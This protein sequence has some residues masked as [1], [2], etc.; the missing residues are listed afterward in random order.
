MT[1]H[2]AATWLRML[3]T[4]LAN[5]LAQLDPDDWDDVDN[6]ID[7]WDT[8]D[9]IRAMIAVHV[10]DLS[11]RAA[12]LLPTAEYDAATGTYHKTTPRTEKWDGFGV[13][14]ALGEPFIDADTGELVRAVP[15]DVLR[16]VLPACGPG[17]T[18]SKW[19]RRALAAH[20]DVERY[21]TVEWGTPVVVRGP[22]PK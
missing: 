22:K 21:S 5:D 8:L 15:V 3:E 9:R 7:A 13:V 11:T 6:T 14:G 16:E 19:K 1:P 10:R 12:K 4:S 2:E 18:S 17:A 20:M